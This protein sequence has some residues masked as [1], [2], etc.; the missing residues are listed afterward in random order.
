LLH[1]LPHRQL[2]CRLLSK[3]ALRVDV[4]A[5]ALQM[6]SVVMLVRKVLLV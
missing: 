5:K 6:C 3:L 2:R 4:S 1:L